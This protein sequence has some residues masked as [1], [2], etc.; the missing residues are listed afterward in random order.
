MHILLHQAHSI[1]APWIILIGKYYYLF[2]SANVYGTSARKK[3]K[4]MFISPLLDTPSYAIGVARAS[5]V[6]GPYEK[7]P[8]NPIVQSNSEFSGPGNFIFFIFFFFFTSF[9][10][11]PQTLLSSHITT[12]HCSV[13]ALN[14]STGPY[15]L[16]YHSWIAGQ[17]GGDYGRMLMLDTFIINDEG[18]PELQ[19]GSPSFLPTPIP[20]S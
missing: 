14:N 12:G 2:Y 8:A 10:S 7:N 9:T 1:E 4:K 18:W 3:K 11:P 6:L 5:A 13:L 20:K 17:V 19:G 15:V 16:L